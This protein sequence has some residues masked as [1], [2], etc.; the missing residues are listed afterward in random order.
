MCLEIVSVRPLLVE[1]G[2]FFCAI[3]GGEP[4]REQL[5]AVGH[6]FIAFPSI[7]EANEVHFCRPPPSGCHEITDWRRGGFF[8]S[9]FISFVV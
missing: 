1:C 5:R 4:H 9:I 6:F 2:L 8:S 3:S 7:L